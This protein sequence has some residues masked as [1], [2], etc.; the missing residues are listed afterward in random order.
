[1]EGK[2]SHLSPGQTLPTNSLLSYEEISIYAQ[3]NIEMDQS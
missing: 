1:M 2:R 3:T